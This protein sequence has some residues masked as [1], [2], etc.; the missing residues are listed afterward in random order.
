MYIR[1]FDGKKTGHCFTSYWLCSARGIGSRILLQRFEC[2]CLLQRLCMHW[3]APVTTNW[4]GEGG[5]VPP[6]GSRKTSPRKTIRDHHT[7]RSVLSTHSVEIL[8][9][10]SL[11]LH[12]FFVKSILD[13]F[14]ATTTKIMFYTLG[15]IVSLYKNLSN[16]QICI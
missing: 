9:F 7:T 2:H 8:A 10:F 16:M 5:P 13:H 6:A 15:G 14:R 3:R 1:V 4:R 12:R 11:P